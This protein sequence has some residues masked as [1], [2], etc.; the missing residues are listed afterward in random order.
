MRAGAC[1]AAVHLEGGRHHAHKSRAGGF[2]YANDA[3]LA[4]LCLLGSFR[5]VLYVDIDIHHCD[6]VEEAFSLTDRVV[7]ASLHKHAPGFFPGTGAAGAA[8]AGRGAGFGLNL[9]LADGVRDGTLVEAF[10]G[11]A[12]GA[13]RLARP[14]AVVLQW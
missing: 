4:V 6:A 9:P 14:D 13:V 5:R 1:R 12:G 7:T 11:L 10:R 8:G 3:V 2:C